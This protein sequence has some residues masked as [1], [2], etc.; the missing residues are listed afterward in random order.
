L[1]ERNAIEK[2]LTAHPPALLNQIP[3]H[4]ADSGDRAAKSK[5]P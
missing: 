1:S 3:L 4:V 2:V 5:Q